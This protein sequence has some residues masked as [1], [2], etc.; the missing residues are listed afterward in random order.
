MNIIDRFVALFRSRPGEPRVYIPQHQGGVLVTEDTAMTLPEWWACVSVISRT[1]ATLPWGVFE[2]TAK[3]RTPIEGGVSWMLNN[4][5]NPEMTAVSFREALMAHVL[6]WGNGYAEIQKDLAGRPTA[7]WLMTPDRVFPERDESTGALRYRV[8]QPDGRTVILE[9]SQVLHVHGLGFDGLVGYSIVQMARRSIGIGIAQ[10]TFGQAFYANG[11]AFGGT[12]EVGATMNKQQIA[13]MESYLNGVHQGP[14]KAFK[15]RVVPQGSKYQNPA[16][17][18]SDAQFVESRALSITAAARWLGVPPHKIA[19]LR[20]R[21]AYGIQP[22]RLAALRV[23][24]GG[25]CAVCR[26]GPATHVD[27]EHNTGRVRGL[28]CH[29]C[30]TGIGMLGDSEAGLVA[31]LGYLR[32][33]QGV[34]ADRTGSIG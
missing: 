14:A 3:G 2:R 17:P 11:T 4:Q 21:W 20:R 15:T 33:T 6:N 25:R 5:P 22:E 26:V 32:R 23:E 12:V 9:P 10:D 28:L 13:D 24:Q 34:E 16:M 1:V 8:T 30:N 29:R 31:A 7:L 27:H 18:L 19:D